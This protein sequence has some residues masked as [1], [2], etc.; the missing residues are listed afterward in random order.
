MNF[1]KQGTTTNTVQAC[2][3]EHAITQ[4][5]LGTAS[6]PTAPQ[7]TCRADDKLMPAGQEAVCKSHVACHKR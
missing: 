3:N 7:V 2:Q 4:L 6:C 5:L 1:R